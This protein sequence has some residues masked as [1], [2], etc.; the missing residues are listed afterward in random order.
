MNKTVNINLA[1]TFFHVDESAFAK[2]I[3]YLK[4]L[5]KGFKNTLVKEEI[6]KYIIARIDELYQEI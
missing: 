6:F 1:S 2:L 5:K 3:A 4:K